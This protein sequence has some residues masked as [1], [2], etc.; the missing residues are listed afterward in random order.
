MEKGYS[1]EYQVYSP[2]TK[3]CRLNTQKSSWKL[4]V[5]NQTSAK[6]NHSEEIKQWLKNIDIKDIP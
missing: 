5:R 1:L 4:N 3:S 2:S 6:T